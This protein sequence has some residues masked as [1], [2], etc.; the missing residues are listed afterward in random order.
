M[1]IH[2]IQLSVEPHL[3]SICFF[4]RFGEGKVLQLQASNADQLVDFS[5]YFFFFCGLVCAVTTCIQCIE[6][7]LYTLYLFNTSSSCNGVMHKLI[8]LMIIIFIQ[9][10]GLSTILKGFLVSLNMFKET[11]SQSL[12]NRMVKV[13]ISD[14]KYFN[15]LTLK[16]QLYIGTLL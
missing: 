2:F 9:G 14:E 15:H 4:H 13:K 5:S 7:S 16:Q 10:W 3:T 6:C 1:I 12:W 8:L 11:K